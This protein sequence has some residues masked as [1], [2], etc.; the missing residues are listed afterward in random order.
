MGTAA[1]ASGTWPIDWHVSRYLNH[2][3]VGRIWRPPAQAWATPGQLRAALAGARFVLLGEQHDNPDH[4]R[5]Q[6]QFLA[7]TVAE[8]RRP[9]LAFE[10]LD[11]RQQPALARFLSSHSDDAAGLG[12]A[13]DWADSGWP[14]WSMYAPIARVALAHDLKIVAANLPV[15]KIEAVARKGYEVLDPDLVHALDLRKPWPAAR[16]EAMLETLYRGHCELMPKS[17]LTG[18]LHA[19]R[20]RDAFMAWRLLRTAGPDG[21]VLIAGAGHARDDYGVPLHLHNHAPAA[22]V[23]SVAL[24]EVRPQGRRPSD[25]AAEFDARRLPFDYVLFTP[26]AVRK[27]PCKALRARFKGHHAGE[28]AP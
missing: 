18:M 7:A 6:A 28:A 11:M 17:A 4:H 10:M 1:A 5:L 23:L 3:L 21:A 15:D 24:V 13:V 2:P 20:T 27:D 16:R 22:S 19:Q 9:T 12:A 26:A 8:G 14:L 25:Y